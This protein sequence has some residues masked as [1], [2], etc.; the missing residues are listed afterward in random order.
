MSSSHMKPLNDMISAVCHGVS[1]Y[2]NYLD[3]QKA[4]TVENSSRAEVE[5]SSTIEDFGAKRLKKVIDKHYLVHLKNLKTV[6]Q[7]K[8]MCTC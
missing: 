2:A 8:D 7:E 1:L 4:K 3:S 6:L 5:D